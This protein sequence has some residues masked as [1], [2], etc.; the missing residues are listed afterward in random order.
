M[1]TT[2]NFY[3]FE[4]AFADHGRSEQFTYEG[5]RIIFNAL[6]ELDESSGTE[7]ELDVIAICCDI[8]EAE[9]DD[10]RNDYAMD[11]DEYPDNDNLLEYLNENTWVLGTTDDTVIFSA[12]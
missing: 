8:Y 9:W 7:S 6:E 12:F 10:V 4:R 11:K 2:V 5:L 1:K 3:D